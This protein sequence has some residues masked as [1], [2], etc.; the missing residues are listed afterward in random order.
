MHP[1]RG[2]TNSHEPVPNF[3][4]EPSVAGYNTSPLPEIWVKTKPKK[5]WKDGLLFNGSGASETL[6]WGYKR[7]HN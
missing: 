1:C 2:G 3:L 4:K 5:M 6:L 7:N